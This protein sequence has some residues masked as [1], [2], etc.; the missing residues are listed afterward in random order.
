MAACRAVLLV[1]LMGLFLLP[2]VGLLAAASRS[3]AVLAAA[4]TLW[5]AVVGASPHTQWGVFHIRGLRACPS[6]HACDTCR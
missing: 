6:I 2:H 1:V 3:S 5:I 4:C